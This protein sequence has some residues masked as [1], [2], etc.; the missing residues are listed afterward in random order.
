MHVQSLWRYPVK[1]MQGESVEQL[2]VDALG[3]AGDRRRAVV[4]A[5]TGVSLSAKRYAALLLCRAW[6]IEGQVMITLPDGT[7]FPADATSAAE[8]LSV[9]LH[10]HVV[11]RMA[12]RDHAVRHEFPSQLPTGAGEPFLWEPGLEGFFDRAPLH[13]I[14]TATLGEFS[15]LQPTSAFD[16]V[17]F[18]PNIV[19]ETD[20][21][22]FVENAW[23]GRE[24]R[25]GTV[26]CHVL[27]TKPRC[28]MTTRPQGA[29]PRDSEV[30][31]TIRHSNAGCGGIELRALEAGRLRHGDPVVLT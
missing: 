3:M 11:I 12:H 15:R 9:L 16:V 6:T 18:R 29:L 23:V 1:S 10:R 28:V 31:K 7:A 19:V 26:A 20:A 5:A 22:G 8:A 24:V 14:T 2:E 17:R 27:A 25:L 21:T 13:L 4:D 30:M